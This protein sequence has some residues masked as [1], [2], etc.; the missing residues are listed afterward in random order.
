MRGVG[1]K[2]GIQLPTVKEN[3]YGLVNG[4]KV[5]TEQERTLFLHV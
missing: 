1:R 4:K 3:V 2:C 5:F